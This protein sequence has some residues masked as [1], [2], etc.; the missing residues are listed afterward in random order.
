MT[1]EYQAALDSAALFDLSDRSK[2]ELA[3]KDSRD[4]LNALCTQD[5]KNLAIGSTCEAFLTTN[6]ARVI[7]H[8][9]ITHR[10]SNV[11]LLDAV[12]GQT[13][14]LLQHLN[15]YL[16]SEQVELAD[17]TQELGMLRLVGPK[18]AELI[19]KLAIMPSRQ[20]RL[21]ALD[22]FDL[23]GL[24]SE[25]STQRQRLIDAGAVLS[26]PSTYQILRIEAGL[27]EYGIDIDEDRLAMEV[28]RTAQAI[29][30]TKGCY[31]GQETIVMARD[32]GQV[33]RLLM[34]VKV[35]S[36]EP[37]TPGTKL[38]RA[39]EEVGHATSSV[40]SPRLGQ[41]IAIAY[42]RRGSCEPGTELVVEPTRDG[43]T[44]VVEALPFCGGAS[45]T[46]P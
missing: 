21:L 39:S 4:F 29:C 42:L 33:N 25:I 16:I 18:A 40:F 8:V 38:F 35:A 32:R 26:G 11:L 3:G 45:L 27:P 44:A 28:N 1:S 34:G 31:L 9:W 7:A 37:L 22:G 5:V 43:R 41:V 2:I 30:Y 19:N 12:A 10:E 6:K 36:G 13:D 46:L 23:I 20:H 14:K 15:R 17:R 24:G